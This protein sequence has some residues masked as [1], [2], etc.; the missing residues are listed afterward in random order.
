MVVEES[1]DVEEKMGKAQM[2][3]ESKEKQ[4]TRDDDRQLANASSR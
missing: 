1:F 4:D 3:F 2:P